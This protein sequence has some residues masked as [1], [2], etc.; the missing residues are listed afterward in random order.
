[1]WVLTRMTAHP[2]RAASCAAASA[3][4]GAVVAVVAMDPQPVDHRIATHAIP[5]QPAVWIN[6]TWRRN[7]TSGPPQAAG[8]DMRSGDAVCQVPRWL[9][10]GRRGSSDRRCDGWGRRWYSTA[11]TFGPWRWST[12]RG[13]TVEV[14]PARA[15]D[16]DERDH[17][18]VDGG[19]R[20]PSATSTTKTA[21]FGVLRRRFDRSLIMVLQP[22]SEP[23][24]QALSAVG[25]R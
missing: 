19:E 2:R 22:R 1:V 7:G 8:I 20:C 11:G 3:S 15:V 5:S 21:R 23:R 12:L 14:P 16:P 17:R 13:N 4:R 18:P 9:G 24:S 10:R 25:M 6:S